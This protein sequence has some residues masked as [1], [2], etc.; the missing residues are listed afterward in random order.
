MVDV[1]SH[2]SFPVP[3]NDPFVPLPAKGRGVACDKKTSVQE[4]LSKLNGF[5]SPEPV[6]PQVFVP[7]L[8]RE[9][10]KNPEANQSPLSHVP[11]HPVLNE[12]KPEDS[13]SNEDPPVM[14][15]LPTQI[16][17]EHDPEEELLSRPLPLPGSFEFDPDYF[18]LH[19]VEE[20]CQVNID[21]LQQWITDDLNSTYISQDFCPM[22]GGDESHIFWASPNQVTTING[23]DGFEVIDLSC[24]QLSQATFQPNQIVL[25]LDQQTCYRVE[26]HDVHTA[27]FADGEVVDLTQR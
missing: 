3:E 1:S 9:P 10:L 4:I 5:C 2:T 8:Q 23:E 25:R 7:P 11:S 6:Q 26:Y 17:D 16:S 15:L 18:D 27:L 20:R 13:F 12:A 14:I 19:S 24:F 22:E 21:K